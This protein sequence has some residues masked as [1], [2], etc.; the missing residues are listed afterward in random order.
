MRDTLKRWMFTLENRGLP[1]V[2][3]AT[4]LIRLAAFTK[5]TLYTLVRIQRRGTN[6]LLLQ[7]HR[8]SNDGTALSLLARRRLEGRPERPP[9]P[10]TD[11]LLMPVVSDLR[12]DPRVERAARTAAAAG[13]H[14]RIVFPKIFEPMTM[15]LTLDWGPRVSFEPL[16]ET[17]A[18]FMSNRIGLW[19]ETIAKAL[20]REP[21]AIIHAHDLS[22]CLMALEASRRT[23]ARVITDF[24]EWWSENVHWDRRTS[25]YVPHRGIGKRAYQAAERLCLRD[26]DEVVTVC[27]SIA[28]A[29]AQE[30][31]NGRR[32]VVVRNIPRLDAVPTREYPPL[33]A[34]LG[35]PED[36]FLLL[37][38][39]GTG[40]TRLIEPIIE[41]LAHAPGCTLLIRGPS[42]DLFGDGY[43][44]LAAKA[45]ASDRLILAPPVP[46]RDVAAAARG[47]DAGIW[48]L[49]ALCRNFTY[50]LPNKIFEY[51]AAGLPVLAADYPEARR[52]VEGEGI[53]AVFDPYDPRSIAAA[54]NGLIDDP[55]H[56]RGLTAAV[57]A[58]LARMQAEAEWAKLAAVYR[59]LAPTERG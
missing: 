54:I 25:S 13:F 44:A 3:L 1:A 57:P 51:M 55:A 12:I 15:A 30:L 26:A 28:D 45:G 21:A 59:R 18:N 43:R 34:Q 19:D 6:Y 33:K 31:G 40:P 17:A 53:G 23:G 29:M 14:V 36:R 41:A 52:L 56:R 47:A 46:S 32:A 38:Q 20:A 24:H 49:P 10:K 58:A 16:P 50:A 7:A 22:T 4:F 37:W 35:L 11:L 9:M 5:K 48:T 2:A 42:L 39:G 8:V 27:D